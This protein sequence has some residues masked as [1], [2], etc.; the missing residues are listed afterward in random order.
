M[1]SQMSKLF[2]MVE[3][4]NATNLYLAAKVKSL[5]VN[6]YFNK[7]LISLNLLYIS[8]EYLAGRPITNPDSES[9]SLIG[10]LATYS[11][12]W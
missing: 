10:R 6:N 5:K 12:G 2:A 4:L 1:N 8:L 7:L 9:R 11:W 3:L